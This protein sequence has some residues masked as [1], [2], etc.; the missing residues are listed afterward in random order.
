MAARPD[1]HLRHGVRLILAIVLGVVGVLVAEK[2][3][4]K[5]RPVKFDGYPDA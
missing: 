4:Q 1:Q 3:R 2:T 5:R